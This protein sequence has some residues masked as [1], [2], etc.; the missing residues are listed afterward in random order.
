MHKEF[1]SYSARKLRQSTE[2]IEDCA[3]RL[4]D[5]QLWWRVAASC[6]APGNLILHLTGNVGQWVICG[7]GGA[8]DTRVRDAEFA[9]TGN[10]SSRERLVSSLR[11]RVDAACQVI[12]AIPEQRLPEHIRV[13]DYEVTVLEAV[14]HVVEHFSHHTGQ[15]LYATKLLTKS[16]LGYYRH[17]ALAAAHSETTP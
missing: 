3:G 14:Y 12:E 16:D 15:I 4:S 9:A 5:E 13:Q 7:I 1:L 10:E 17:L 11:S 2:R 6:N 8:P